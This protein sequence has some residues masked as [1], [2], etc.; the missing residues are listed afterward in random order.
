MS[1]TTH[2]VEFSGRAGTYFGIWIVNLLLSILTIGIYSAWAKVR[3]QRYL[4]QN[5]TIDGRAFDYHA[6]GLQILIGRIIVVA[7]FVA[8]SLLA[9]I[10]LFAVVLPI[11]LIFLIPWLL[12]RSLAFN[13]RVTSFSG[14]RFGFDGSYWRAFRVYI[15]YPVLAVFTLYL[16]FPFVARAVRSHVVNGHRFGTARFRFESGIGPFYKAFLMAGLWAVGTGLLLLALFAPLLA[17]FDPSAFR[18]GTGDPDPRQVLAALVPAAIIVLAILPAGFIYQA[19]IR[20]AVFAATTLEGGHA[21]TSD[22][23]PLRLVWIGVSNAVAVV[24]SLGL[25]LPWARI[26]MIAYQ[27][28]HTHVTV[29]GSLD[30]FTAAE[31]EKVGAIGQAYTDIEGFDVG[32]PV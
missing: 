15:L 26:R 13:A 21:F 7:A 2:R 19:F 27:A 29:N 8:Y 17:G 16:A 9:A 5:L 4:N 12:N 28:A 1:L 11:G 24:F 14:L 25:L 22:I 30:T 20:N 10:P 3:T 32:L 23:A 18:T 6:T 31:A